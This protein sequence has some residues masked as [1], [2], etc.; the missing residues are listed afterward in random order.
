MRVC[1]GMPMER[2]CLDGRV[3]LVVEDEALVGL[4]VRDLLGDYGATVLLARNVKDALPLADRPE[5]AAAVLDINLAG[6]DCSP[7]CH[8]LSERG[9]PF[10]FH[11]GY[12]SAAVLEQW[13]SAPVVNKP[14]SGARIIE[15]LTGLTYALHKPAAE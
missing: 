2:R 3:V 10:M 11:T 13:S 15:A 8:R 9:I 5:L 1:G 6:E 4:D 14:A 12:S 7:I